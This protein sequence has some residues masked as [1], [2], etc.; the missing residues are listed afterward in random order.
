[1]SFMIAVKSVTKSLFGLSMVFC[2]GLDGAAQAQE[3]DVELAN[4]GTISAVYIQQPPFISTSAGGEPVGWIV[5]LNEEVSKELGIPFKYYTSDASRAMQATVAGSYDIVSSILYETPERKQHVAFTRSIFV[6]GSAVLSRPEEA[7]ASSKDLAGKRVGATLGT[8][9]LKWAEEKL[10]DAQVV[11]QSSDA[12]AIGQLITG[13]IDAFVT[14]APQAADILL[15]Q[16][17]KLKLAFPVPVEFPSA[18]AVGKNRP[19]LLA[20]INK[21][22]AKIVE[23]GRFMKIYSK[24]FGDYPI[25]EE[26]MTEWPQLR[27]QLAR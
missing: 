15:K 4:K 17:S 24:T 13:N 11:T 14:G 26:M 22:L 7:I 23:D 20:A 25:P 16:G 2:L 10:T 1:M 5:D 27:A 21:A 19:K 3:L 8:L 12:T 18:M 9:Q 6:G